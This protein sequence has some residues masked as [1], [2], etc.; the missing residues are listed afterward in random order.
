MDPRLT[1]AMKHRFRLLVPLVLAVSGASVAQ[2]I[3]KC[4]GDDSSVTYQ[5]APCAPAQSDAGVL[6]LPGYA[7]PAERDGATAPAADAAAAASED[8]PFPA[9]SSPAMSDAQ[10]VFPFRTSVAVGMTDDQVL[11][12]PA[13]G[14][15]TTIVRSGS[16]ANWREVWTYDRGGDIRQL[17]FVGG[18]L[19]DIQT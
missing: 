8:T 1:N 18:R 5:N 2:D 17:A 6:R 19:A 12:V 3:H 13:W 15:P 11:N 9:A 16:H 4:V 14:R 10:R 7:D